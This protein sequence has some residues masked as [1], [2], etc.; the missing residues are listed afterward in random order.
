MWEISLPPP[1]IKIDYNSTL[2]QNEMIN[3]I[4][5]LALKGHDIYSVVF[6]KLHC[7][8]CEF[9]GAAN[10]KQILSKEQAH[11]KQKIEE[12]QLQLTSPSLESKEFEE[13]S[14]GEI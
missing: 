12:V 14:D 3:E 1:L 10:L 5:T 7:L 8:P 11:F 13:E 6:E 2:L 4:K 9:E